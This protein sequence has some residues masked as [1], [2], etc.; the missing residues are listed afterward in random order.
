LKRNASSRRFDK[1]DEPHRQQS[2]RTVHQ[3]DISGGRALHVRND[4]PDIDA[5]E[6]LAEMDE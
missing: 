1:N 6:F 4:A 5:D 2:E 3:K